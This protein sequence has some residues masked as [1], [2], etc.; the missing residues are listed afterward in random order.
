LHAATAN[1]GVAVA[2]VYP[3]VS[4]TCNLGLHA[5]DASYLT[6]WASHFYLAG[7]S[8]SLPILQGGKLSA[9]LRMARAQQKEAALH[10]RS[11]ELNA[12]REVD[13]GLF[14]YRTDRATR[15]RLADTDIL[16]ETRCIWRRADIATVCLT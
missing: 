13:D 12:L 16:A 4:L 1:V 15:E 7:P 9:S 14:A 10:Y 8:I 2:S 5:T 6:R 3:D 11:T